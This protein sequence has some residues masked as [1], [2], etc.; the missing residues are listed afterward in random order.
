MTAIAYFNGKLAADS[1]T[2]LDSTRL[3]PEEKVTVLNLKDSG[4]WLMAEAGNSS[5]AR[6]IRRAVTKII[7]CSE[8]K[9][10]L[11]EE[12]FERRFED[13]Y[14]HTLD[15]S[16]GTVV[17]IVMPSGDF[18]VVN[19]KY[20]VEGRY[21]KETRYAAGQAWEFLLGC[22]DS[23]KNPTQAVYLA[24]DRYT[25]CG[26]PVKTYIAGKGESVNGK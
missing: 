15:G 10:A 9:Q 22:M 19:G 18:W 17:I 23:G 6:K 7:K 21:T 4:V 25:G 13:E 3:A 14:E 26:A 12:E 2:T 11:T 1:L 20:G 5:H 24:C 16:E 8:R